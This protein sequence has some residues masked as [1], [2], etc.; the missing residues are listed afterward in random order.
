MESSLRYV[1]LN[2]YGPL[3]NSNGFFHMHASSNI[4]D[5]SVITSLH[6]PHAGLIF[7]LYLLLNEGSVT[8]QCLNQKAVVGRYITLIGADYWPI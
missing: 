7:T 6:I 3:A 1:S 5:Q 8:R 2:Q 4:I